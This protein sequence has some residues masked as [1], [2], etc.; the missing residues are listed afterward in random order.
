MKT[1]IKAILISV[2]LFLSCDTCES[3]KANGE[4]FYISEIKGTHSMYGTKH[5]IRKD[6]VTISV[7]D[8]DG[9]KYIYNLPVEV[10]TCS[11]TYRIYADK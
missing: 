7:T 11:S 10:T 9:N 3:I 1:I 8:K 6:K 4:K 5:T 2:L